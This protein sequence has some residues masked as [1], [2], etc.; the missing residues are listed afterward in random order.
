MT[1]SLLASLLRRLGFHSPSLHVDSNFL[2]HARHA[3]LQRSEILELDKTTGEKEGRSDSH[4]A[5]VEAGNKPLK[6]PFGFWE[7]WDDENDRT[8]ALAELTCLLDSFAGFPTPFTRLRRKPKRAV[9][10]AAFYYHGRGYA[11]ATLAESI[12]AKATSS[13]IERKKPKSSPRGDHLHR[14]TA[15]HQTG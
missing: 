10:G 7:P 11:K 15:A 13:A 5:L 4:R 14:H 9:R 12:E 3:C 1:S 8:D 6:S 2:S